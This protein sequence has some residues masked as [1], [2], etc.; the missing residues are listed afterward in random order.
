M[1]L[2]IG[3]ANGAAGRGRAIAVPARKAGASVRVPMAALRPVRT[4]N[5]LQASIL[6]PADPA[7]LVD[8]EVGR[9]GG[10]RSSEL[11]HDRR[12]RR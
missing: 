5:R 11:R 3:T 9:C 8:V 12:E 2:A 4:A 7:G 6:G 1:V 10:V